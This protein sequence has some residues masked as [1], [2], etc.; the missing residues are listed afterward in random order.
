MKVGSNVESDLNRGEVTR[1]II[2]DPANL[3]KGRK[4]HAGPT[5]NILMIDANQIW[6]VQ[7]IVEYV[8]R[9]AEIK[10]GL[11]RSPLHLTSTYP[12]A[13]FVSFF[14]LTAIAPHD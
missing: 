5:G 10:P 3:P 11:S 4:P 9:L 13:T 1:S 6:G 7:H 8:K 14:L 12:S 2:D